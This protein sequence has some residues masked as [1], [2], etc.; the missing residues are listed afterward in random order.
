VKR[1]KGEEQ[2]GT[3]HGGTRC[4]KRKGGPKR[5]RESERRDNDGSKGPLLVAGQRNNLSAQK[6]EQ[7][8]EGPMI[9]G[10]RFNA[11]KPRIESKK[12]E[13]SGSFCT[14]KFEFW[15]VDGRHSSGLTRLP[16]N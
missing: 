11:I 12:S 1:R 15:R 6:D 13:E 3:V 10:G 5:E 2:M 14:E 9:V 8:K 7:D 4:N 16:L